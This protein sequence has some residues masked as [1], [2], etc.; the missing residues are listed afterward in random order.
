MDIIKIAVKTLNPN[1]VPVIAADQLLY[2]LLKQIQWSYRAT[3]DDFGGLHIEAAF[4]CTIGNWLRDSGWTNALTQAK[5]A[6][7]GTA[8][9]FLKAS[10]ITRT[11]WAH[12][13]SACALYNLMKRAHAIYLQVT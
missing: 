9:S 2:S 5:V 12:Q 1:Q 8:D 6:T 7:S 3:H 13:V 10:H 11:R 4:E